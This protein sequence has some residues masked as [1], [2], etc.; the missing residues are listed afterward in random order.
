[1]YSQKLQEQTREHFKNIPF[2][3]MKQFGGKFGIGAFQG[4][5]YIVTDRKTYEKYIFESMDKLIENGWAID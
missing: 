3:A 5:K 1:M 4:G 2:A